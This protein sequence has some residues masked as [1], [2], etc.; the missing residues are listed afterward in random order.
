M[1]RYVQYENGEPIGAIQFHTKGPRSKKAVISNIYVKE[2]KRRQKIASG[3]LRRAQQD[4][5]IKHSN[6]LTNDGKAFKAADGKTYTILAPIP[7]AAIGAG[8][9]ESKRD[10]K[11]KH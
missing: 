11:A 4:F 5:D 3:L 2:E 9:I 8:V 6:D 7:A 10:N 1:M